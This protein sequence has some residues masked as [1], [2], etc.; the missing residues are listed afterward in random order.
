[1]FEINNSREI[2]LIHAFQLVPRSSQTNHITNMIIKTVL[3]GLIHMQRRACLLAFTGARIARK[4]HT[5]KE[6]AKNRLPTKIILLGLPS[7]T[8]TSSTG[9]AWRGK[10]R[11]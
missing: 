10:A 8:T 11:P 7:A 1:M 9:R 3:L 6:T 2:S 4:Q 5:R